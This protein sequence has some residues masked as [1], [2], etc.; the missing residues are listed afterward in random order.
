MN[1]YKEKCNDLQNK[2]ESDEK[3]K[4]NIVFFNPEIILHGRQCKSYQDQIDCMTDRELSNI[5]HNELVIPEL[6][7]IVSETDVHIN[8]IT[9][10]DINEEYEIG[11]SYDKDRKETFRYKLFEYDNTEITPNVI[12]SISKIQKLK[13][14]ILR[15]N[16]EIKLENEKIINSECIKSARSIDVVHSYSKC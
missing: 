3:I 16:H 10:K 8:Y 12:E 2:L 1:S 14:E 5:E 6:G 4:G 13:E 15:L 7:I 9:N 11:S